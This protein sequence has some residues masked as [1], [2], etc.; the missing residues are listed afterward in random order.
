[1]RLWLNESG[2]NV[3][4]YLE[5]LY[6]SPN[7]LVVEMLLTSSDP[8]TSSVLGNQHRTKGCLEFLIL[9]YHNKRDPMLRTNTVQP[10]V[11]RG[12]FHGAQTALAFSISSHTGHRR[13]FHGSLRPR[14]R[15]PTLRAGRSPRRSVHTGRRCPRSPARGLKH[16]DG[17]WTV[18]DIGG[19]LKMKRTHA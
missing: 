16:G 13:S 5:F 18:S 17:Q 19:Q 10:D 4:S 15:E 1:M 9:P 11:S 2:T 12:V 3:K 14:A 8:C 7:L 6:S